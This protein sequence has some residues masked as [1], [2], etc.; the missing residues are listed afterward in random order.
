MVVLGLKCGLAKYA[1]RVSTDAHGLVEAF[2]MGYELLV[3]L[4]CS[5]HIVGNGVEDLAVDLGLQKINQYTSKIFKVS[6]RYGP[7]PRAKCPSRMH[8]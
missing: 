4:P 5:D 1:R 6:I 3:L 8:R 2:M 7:Q